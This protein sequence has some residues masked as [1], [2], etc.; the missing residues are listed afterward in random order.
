MGDTI[1]GAIIEG[2]FNN[3]PMMG[4]LVCP[5]G[6]PPDKDTGVCPEAYAQA[7]EAQN[8]YPVPSESCASVGAVGGGAGCPTRAQYGPGAPAP[9]LAGA[10]HDVFPSHPRAVIGSAHWSIPVKLPGSKDGMSGLNHW[11]K[12]EHLESVAIVP[13][14]EEGYACNPDATISLTEQGGEIWRLIDLGTDFFFADMY[15][16]LADGTREFIQPGN[17]EKVRLRRDGTTFTPRGASLCRFG[18]FPEG[19]TPTIPGLPKNG[20]YFAAR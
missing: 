10:D 11:D 14:K 5:D 9:S 18:A 3:V 17:M 15:N 16:E 20:I 8:Y 2:W 7:T 12:L 1:E 4:D 13:Y 6:A 19:Y